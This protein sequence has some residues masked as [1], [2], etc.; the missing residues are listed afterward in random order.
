MKALL[1]IAL[2]F[3]TTAAFA[4]TLSFPTLGL[5]VQTE[6]I[7]KPVVNKETSMSLQILNA[8][9]T[10][11]ELTDL[12]EVEL[13]MPDMGHGSGPTSFE[14]ILDENDEIIPGLFKVRNM[15]FIMKGK[16]DVRVT[17]TKDGKAETQIIKVKL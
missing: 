5:T 15:W 7:A 4:E 3:I 16:W 2:A 6:W 8:D 17:L 12:P 11:V 9:S 14:R 10:R 1:V 13:Y